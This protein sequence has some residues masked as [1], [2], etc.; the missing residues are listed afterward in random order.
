LFNCP[1]FVFLIAC[2]E[3]E[4][5]GTAVKE[6]GGGGA[7]VVVVDV[8]VVV[9]VDGGVEVGTVVVVTTGWGNVER[10]VADRT[11]EL[12]SASFS[13]MVTTLLVLPEVSA[14]VFPLEER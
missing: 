14:A 2:D 3:G 7:V 10:R 9:V 13:V 12:P 8:D 11:T 1:V 4:A 5:V 6:Q